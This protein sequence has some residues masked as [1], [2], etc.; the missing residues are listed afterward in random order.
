MATQFPFCHFTGIEVVPNSFLQDFPPLPNVAFERG[1][2][3]IQIL[4]NLDDNSIDYIHLRACSSFLDSDQWHQGL[5]EMYRILKPEGVIR[6]EDFHNLASGTVMIESF[7]ETCKCLGWS[8][9]TENNPFVYI[10]RNIAASSR[11]DFDIAPKLGNVATQHHF[12]IIESK[13]KRIHYGKREKKKRG[14]FYS[15]VC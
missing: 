6:M 13:K 7:V 12:Q 9:K 4:Q 11:F 14:L 15:L 1:L 8:L 10:V 3:W 5:T 2:P